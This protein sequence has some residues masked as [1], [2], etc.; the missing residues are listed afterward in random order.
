MSRILIAAALAA[1]FAAPA[2]ADRAED[3]L[4]AVKRALGE[5]AGAKASPPAED[6]GQGLEPSPSPQARRAGPKRFRIR[7]VERGRKHAKV[8][9]NLPL[10]LV[11]AIGEGWRVQGCQRCE[12][13]RGPTLGEVLRALDSGQNLV[14]IDDD[15]TT[16]RVWVE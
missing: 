5:T 8:S 9:V 10:A 14:E 11:R 16:V 7:V 15:E 6:P 3:D 4:A 2:L 1:A 13:G 12:Q